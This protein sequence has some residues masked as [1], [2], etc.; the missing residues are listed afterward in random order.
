MVKLSII[1]Y[2]Y[3]Y[4]LVFIN[5]ASTRVKNTNWVYSHGNYGQLLVHLLC[6][7]IVQTIPSV[8]RHHNCP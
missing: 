1:G 7:I 8:Q 3:T 5:K 4:K 2:S 6:D